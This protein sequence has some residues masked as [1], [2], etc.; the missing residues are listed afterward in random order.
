MDATLVYEP[1]INAGKSFSDWMYQLAPR[2]PIFH[3]G[4]VSSSCGIYNTN[5]EPAFIFKLDNPT[6]VEYLIATGEAF[7]GQAKTW[8]SRNDNKSTCSEMSN[9][10]FYGTQFFV[11]ASEAVSGATWT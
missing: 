5:S 9:K 3:A 7:D 10:Y 2:Y 8:S 1:T 6:Y 4:L 11:S